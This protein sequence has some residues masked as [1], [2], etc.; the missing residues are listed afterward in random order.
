M[1]AVDMCNLALT[2]IGEAPNITS[3][4]PPLD[5]P[6]AQVCAAQYG[7]ALAMVTASRHWSFANKR[8]EL[9]KPRV[10]VSSVD[11]GSDNITTATAHGFATN[12]RATFVRLTAGA[13]TAPGGLT[14]DTTYY[15][16]NGGS[17]TVRLTD[18]ED[19]AAINITSAGGG[20]F[21]L[22]RE[23]DRPGESM[24]AL[25][26]DC[27]V[28]R[29]VV[30]HGAPDDQY[31]LQGA[32]IGTPYSGVGVVTGTV[33]GLN[34]TYENGG[35]GSFRPIP[36]RRAVNRAGESVIYTVLA[37][38]DLLYTYA[39]SDTAQM[40]P[41]FQDAVVF[42]LASALAGAIKRDTKLAREMLMMSVASISEAARIDA[43]RTIEAPSRRFPF[44]R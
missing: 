20:G 25:P 36:A 14:F 1:N 26:S 24:F 37:E 34:Y 9:A 29:F 23:S 43:Q 41:E 2:Y 3:I 42:R 40:T 27:L 33:D 21:V 6:H 17:T 19:G 4:T 5:S 11:T 35:F 12:D 22:E 39:I 8:A 16:I 15:V 28:E 32:L 44:A 38:P 13:G 7:H 10:S 30:P 31:G 18:E